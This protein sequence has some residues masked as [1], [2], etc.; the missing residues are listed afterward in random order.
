MTPI[1]I[2]GAGPGDPGLLTVRAHSLLKEAEVV[3]YDRLVSEAVL[4]LA[5]NAERVYVGKHEGEQQHIQ[6]RIYEELVRYAQQGKFVVRLKGGDPF[7]FGRGREEI[8]YLEER[9]FQV[10][11]VPGVS[12]AIGVPG[13]VGIPVTA[14]NISRSFAVVTGHSCGESGV[15]WKD[16]AKIETLV[17]L[18]GVKYREDIAQDLIAAGRNEGEKVAFI[19]NGS[20]EDERVVCSTLGEVAKGGVVVESPAVWVIGDVVKFYKKRSASPMLGAV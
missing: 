10:E 14:R 4:E 3:L 5:P 1:A 16:Y 17:V 12:S 11:L 18:M 15:E 7:V 13:L 9:G 19:E 2:I 6:E 20:S 8:D